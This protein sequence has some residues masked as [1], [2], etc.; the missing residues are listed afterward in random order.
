ME[1]TN[2]GVQGTSLTLLFNAWL[3]WIHAKHVKRIW[4]EGSES[5]F[6]VQEQETTA[7]QWLQRIQIF[8]APPFGVPCLSLIMFTHKVRK[9]A[10]VCCWK[11]K[12]FPYTCKVYNLQ[13]GHVLAHCQCPF[14][15]MYN[16]LTWISYLFGGLSHQKC[17]GSQLSQTHLHLRLSLVLYSV[18]EQF[19]C[20][21]YR[22]V[23][24]SHGQVSVHH[25]LHVR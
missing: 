13:S 10:T 6:L 1:N 5:L 24:V 21:V 3:R 9:L 15:L 17:F 11:H 25:I 20:S 23:F 14:W 16:M 22:T 7:G 19:L 8:P 4:S 2:S 18:I 12:L